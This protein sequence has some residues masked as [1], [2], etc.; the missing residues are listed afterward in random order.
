MGEYGVGV[1]LED[2]EVAAR[3]TGAFLAG[4][5]QGAGFGDQ[6]G[7]LFGGGRRLFAG[8]GLVDQDD[9]FGELAEPLK[10]GI[11]ENQVEILAGGSDAGDVALICGAF[12]IEQRFVEAEQA[13]A[14]FFHAGTKVGHA[15]IVS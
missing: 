8:H 12:A 6:L 15:T 2:F 7:G 10:P 1:A 4:H 5:K 13:V 11:V 14:D 3:K 9:E